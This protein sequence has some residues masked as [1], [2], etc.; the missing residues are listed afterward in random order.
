LK[1]LRNDFNTAINKS[2][3]FLFSKL[4]F[5]SHEKKFTSDKELISAVLNHFKD[6]NSE[7]FFSD[8]EK[9]I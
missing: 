2:D 6:K 7:Y 8:I 1:F 9:L 3:Y 5:E 4:K